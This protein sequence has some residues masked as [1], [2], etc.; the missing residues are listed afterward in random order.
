MRTLRRLLLPAVVL[1]A[2]V[3]AIAGAVAAPAPSHLPA[4]ALGAVL[5]WRVEVSAAAFVVAYLAI[6]TVRLALHG[7]TFTRV[8]SGGVEIPE[9]RSALAS[10][11]STT[12][13]ET[14]L[15]GL[16]ATIREIE[17]RL[18]ALEDA[19]HLLLRFDRGDLA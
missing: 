19:R 10:K 4:V 1:L 3:A 6:V 2:L 18:S 8:G 13:I 14:S 16:A 17:A 5:L 11:A 7:R 12:E 15:A 9:V